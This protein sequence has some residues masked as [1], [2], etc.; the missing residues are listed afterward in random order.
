MPVEQSNLKSD[1]YQEFLSTKAVVAAAAGFEVNPVDLNENLFPFQRDLVSWSLRKGRAALFATTGLG[2]TICQLS[3]AELA[4]RRSL[5]IAPLAVAHQT[6]EEGAKWGI[7]ITYARKM[8]ESPKHGITIINYEMVEHFD[9]SKFGAVVLDESSCLKHFEGKRRSLLIKL[10]SVIPLR[11]CCTATPAPND[12]SEIANHAEFL[13]VMTRTEMLSTF[14]VHD[15]DGWRLKKHGRDAFHKWLASWAMS[16]LKP[17]DIGHSDAGYDLPELKIIPV[18][19]PSTYIPDGQLFPTRLHGVGDRAKVRKSTVVERVR[20]AAEIIQREPD[21]QWLIWCGLNDEADVIAKALPGAINVQGSDSIERKTEILMGFGR[22]EVKLMI[23]KAKIAGMGMNFQ[24]AA[25]MLFLGMNDSYEEYFQGIRR[26]WRFGQTRPVNVYIVLTDIEMDIFDNVLRKERE[27]DA[28]T[29]E[30]IKHVAEF[31]KAEIGRVTTRLDY[32]A[33]QPMEI[34]KWLG[35]RSHDVQVMN[36]KHGD[37]Y[38]IYHGDSCEVLAGLPENSIDLSVYSPPFGSLFTYSATER[39]L[40][41]CKTMTEFWSHFQFIS[42]NMLRVLKPGRSMCVHVAQIPMM[43]GRD[44]YIGMMDFR[45][46]TIR[47][48]IDKGFIYYGEICIQKNPQSQA[49]RTKSKSLM[50]VQLRKDSSW[51]RPALADYIL[52]FHKPG[53]NEVAIHPDVSHEQWIKWAHPV[54][55]DIK[56]TAT[57]SAAEGRGQEDEKHI[58]PLQLET[59]ERCIRLWSN[60]GEIVLTPFLGIGTEVYES[61]LLGRRGIG[62]ELKPEYFRAASKNMERAIYASGAQGLFAGL[63]QEEAAI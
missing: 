2:K 55:Y 29:K 33:K 25:R 40:G 58:A 24:S 36:Q 32:D 13:G 39:D 30:L 49:I 57:L 21:E 9:M 16:L 51:L 59:V 7:P 63:E 11:L 28:M 60:P 53:E 14:F 20:A 62:C 8:E 5:V 18:V 22:G 26:E 61:L 17:S 50:F 4:A 42:S 27:A 56:E 19:V 45:G 12:I 44:G 23:S 3:W 1:S 6:V 37:D 43:K 54:W 10:C 38:S 41:N 35:E 47:H 34:P 31:E 46:E 15:E 52:I 48:F